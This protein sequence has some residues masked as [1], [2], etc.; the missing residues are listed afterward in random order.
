MSAAAEAGTGDAG[1]AALQAKNKAALAKR[2]AAAAAEKDAK[3]KLSLPTGWTRVAS[4]SR[5]G[6]TVYQNQHTGDKQAWF[7]DAPAVTPAIPVGATPEE[8]AKEA[9]KENK[10]FTRKDAIAAATAIPG[11]PPQVIEAV[12]AAMYA[13]NELSFSGQSLNQETTSY[14]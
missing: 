6:E 2:K 12:A 14:S 9:M 10:A 7:P 3:S 8:T 5:P 13:V 4:T 11:V 1:K